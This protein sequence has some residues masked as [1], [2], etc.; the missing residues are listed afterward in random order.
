MDILR[1]TSAIYNDDYTKN[2]KM[3]P[4]CSRFEVQ[5]L[6]VKDKDLGPWLD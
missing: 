1:G 5:G 3:L 2:Y 6:G 4:E